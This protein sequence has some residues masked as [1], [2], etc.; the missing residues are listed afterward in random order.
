MSG[1][2]GSQYGTDGRGLEVTASRVLSSS[3][4]YSDK[5]DTRNF[6]S[7]DWIIY[8]AN[9]GSVTRVDSQIQF[10]EKE[11]A[12]VAVL[13]DWCTE[14]TESI[15]DGIGVLSDYTLQKTIT[16]ATTFAASSPL[17]GKWMRVGVKAG[18]GSVTGSSYR[19]LAFRRN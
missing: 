6:W 4:V 10:S 5:I 17:R 1:V 3:Y 11:D 15:S 12:Y 13:L 7:I 19:V 8:I 2:L 9:A 18:A 14:Q 16:G